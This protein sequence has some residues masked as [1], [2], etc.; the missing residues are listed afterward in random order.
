MA[1]I[2]TREFGRTTKGEKVTAFELRGDSGM[3]VRILDYGGT[4]QRLIVPDR[5]G[6]PTDVVLGYDDIASYEKGNSCYG[7]IVGR[8]ANRIR[9]GGFF[10]DGKEY[11]LPMSSDEPNHL[12]GVFHRKVFE[13]AIDGEALVLRY[14]SP[15]Q[16]DGFPG[17]LSLEVR[18]RLGE[19]SSLEITYAAVT[20]APTVLN[21][22][23][24][25]YFNLNGQDGSTV[26]DHKIRLNSS[27][28]TEYSKTLSQTGKIIPVENTPFDFREEHTIGERCNAEYEQL[29][30]CTGYDHNMILDGADGKMKPIG[31]AKSDKSGIC[32]EAFTTEPAIQFYC[33]NFIHCDPVPYGKNGVRYPR[34]GGFCME[35]QHYPDSV[36]HWYFPRTI[37]RPDETYRQTTEYRFGTFI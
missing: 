13:A 7:A 35:A 6:T 16:E 31:T 9:A 24:H 1:A 3:S 20:D 28:F 22:T 11:W 17:N 33:A 27:N 18:Y 21:L 15:D 5:K 26:L 32:L 10:L 23:N 19:G 30:L 25:S 29:K 37:L 14:L 12:H 2:H 36:H 34:N 8:Y 4:V